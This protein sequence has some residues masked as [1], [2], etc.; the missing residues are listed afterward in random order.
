MLLADVFYS[1]S[2]G[3]YVTQMNHVIKFCVY[4]TTLQFEFD[5]CLTA[6]IR[7]HKT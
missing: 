1:S 4:V 5:L 6:V 7:N 2:Q 3:T